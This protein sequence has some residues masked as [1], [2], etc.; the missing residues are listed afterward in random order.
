MARVLRASKRITKDKKPGGYQACTREEMREIL[1]V[2]V[3]AEEY[4]VADKIF[5][6]L[7]QP[8]VHQMLNSAPVGQKR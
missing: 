6:K 7:M 2:P 8:Q 4:E 1:S 5:L 3:S